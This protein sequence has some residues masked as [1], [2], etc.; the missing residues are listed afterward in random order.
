MYLNNYC[1]N[2]RGSGLMTLKG[3]LQMVALVSSKILFSVVSKQVAFP[4]VGKI[5]PF[6]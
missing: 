4:S 3:L 5:L 1:R 2:F 6:V